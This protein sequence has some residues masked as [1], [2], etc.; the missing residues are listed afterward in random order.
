MSSDSPPTKAQATVFARAVNL[1][2][3]DVPGFKVSSAPETQHETAA[4][5]RLEHDLQ[6]CVHAASGEGLVEESSREFERE[7]SAGYQS[8]QSEVTVVRTAALA[9]KELAVIRGSRTRA[10]VSHEFD[11]LLKV[12]KY[13][14]AT[15]SPVSVVQSTPSAPG[16]E[17]SFA[18]RISVTI[19][20]RGLRL[21]FYVDILGF[22]Y[23]PAE[24]SLFTTSFP[25]SFPAATEQRLFS[26]LVDRA[27]AHGL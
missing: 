17:G 7:S 27:K 9:A 18:W 24:V 8:V 2:V 3:A 16:A 21:P 12:Q 19:T 10:C 6:R 26:L 4:E 1:N 22:A 15:I 20:V 14:G 11:L 5:K 13:R 25:R 23:G